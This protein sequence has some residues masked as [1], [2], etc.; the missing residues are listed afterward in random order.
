M[1]TPF[2][3]SGSMVSWRDPEDGH[4]RFAH[5][6]IIRKLKPG[7]EATSPQA[8]AARLILLWTSMGSQEAE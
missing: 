2:S 7:F 1:R 3:C 8:D 6:T 5:P 4:C